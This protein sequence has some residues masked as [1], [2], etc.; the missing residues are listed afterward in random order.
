MGKA[1]MKIGCDGIVGERA[2][3]GE[4]SRVHAIHEAAEMR[5]GFLIRAEEP[6]T[7]VGDGLSVQGVLDGRCDLDWTGQKADGALAPEA[8]GIE[9]GMLTQ[10]RGRGVERQ[11]HGNEAG[12]AGGNSRPQGA[13]AHLAVHGKAIS[14]AG[15]QEVREPLRAGVLIDLEKK[16]GQHERTAVLR[17]DG[18]EPDL[19][20]GAEGEEEC[21]IRKAA[22]DGELRPG[23]T[24]IMPASSPWQ[25]AM[26]YRLA[27]W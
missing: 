16:A 9:V 11:A 5:A 17:I 20:R 7:T 14:D 13:E 23:W 12:K 22:G 4:D 3:P 27:W 2:G 21:G 6:W 26:K 24:E 8:G 19:K 18:E 1:G 15:D 10:F 25:R